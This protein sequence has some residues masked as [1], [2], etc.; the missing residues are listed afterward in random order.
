ML[1]FLQING[2]GEQPSGLLFSPLSLTAAASQAHAGVLL[3]NFYP[4]LPLNCLFTR[5]TSYNKALAVPLL[6]QILLQPCGW[7][8]TAFPKGTRWDTHLDRCYGLKHIV[9]HLAACAQ[10]RARQPNDL[11]S[12][13]WN[14]SFSAQRCVTAASH[15]CCLASRRHTASASLL[16]CHPTGKRGK[17]GCKCKNRRNSG[18]TRRKM[19]RSPDHRRSM[20]AKLYNMMWGWILH[21]ICLC[22]C[23]LVSCRALV[24][25]LRYMKAQFD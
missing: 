13:Y 18:S 11:R 24:I 3:R 23:R 8:G 25:I 2:Q 16:L 21:I 15:Y 4:N 20:T 22:C 7:K 1:T 10:H 5:V 17:C 6:A 9:R 19:T 14:R 12:V